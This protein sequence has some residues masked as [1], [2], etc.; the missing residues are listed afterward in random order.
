MHK[1]SKYFIKRRIQ[2]ILFLVQPC[3]AGS[4]TGI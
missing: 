2:Y 3:I 4:K 1:P